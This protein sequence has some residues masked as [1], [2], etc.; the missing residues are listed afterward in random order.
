[1]GL[2]N[3][4][5]VLK[6]HELRTFTAEYPKDYANTKGDYWYKPTCDVV[7]ASKQG[8]WSVMADM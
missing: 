4:F 7:T 1:M 5:L 8:V 2:K 6:A 3:T